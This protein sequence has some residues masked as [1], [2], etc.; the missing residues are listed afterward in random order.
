MKIK[1]ALFFLI[2]V[3]SVFLFQSCSIPEEERAKIINVIELRE[4]VMN[5]GDIS[6]YRAL[7]SDSFEDLG[8]HMEQMKL[9]NQYL[10]GFHYLFKTTQVAR[11]SSFGKKADIDI[12]FDLTYKRPDDPAPHVWLDRLETVS[13]IKEGIG[14]RISGVKDIK[15]SGIM[16]SPEIV[17]GIYHTLDTRISALNNSDAE[18]F[19]TIVSPDY[20]GREE[21]LSNFTAN[22]AVFS[23]INYELAGRR[24]LFISPNMDEARLEQIY[25]LSF[26]ITGTEDFERFKGQKEIISLRKLPGQDIWI[27]TDGLK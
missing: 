3:L 26:K 21:I 4:H 12:E 13:F 17:Q 22:K 25:S 18:L 8:G 19:D 23:D 10:G 7:L 16:I 15:N 1:Q 6:S 27:I 9:R 14:W 20:P 11:V 24:F 2:A 5:E